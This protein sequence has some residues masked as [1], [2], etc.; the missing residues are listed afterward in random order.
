MTIPLMYNKKKVTMYPQ[1]LLAKKI[2]VSDKTCP[3]EERVK[4]NCSRTRQHRKVMST[5]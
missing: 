3:T 5:I 2:P 4:T 1:V